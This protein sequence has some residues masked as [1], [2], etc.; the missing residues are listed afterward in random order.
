MEREESGLLVSS[1]IELEQCIQCQ[2][3]CYLCVCADGNGLWAQCS[4]Q[5]S[6]EV[7]QRLLGLE[8]D[9]IHF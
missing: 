4:P 5:L 1:V 3:E 6:V 2:C 8:K 7:L 9:K